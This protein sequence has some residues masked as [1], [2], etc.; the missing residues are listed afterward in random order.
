MAQE[1][2]LRGGTTA[3]HTTFTGAAKEVTVDTTKNILVVHDGATPGGH[4]VAKQSEVDN[5]L[6]LK[7]DALAV[8]NALAL[9]ADTTSVDEALALK[10][11][12]SELATVKFPGQISA[13]A[14]SSAPSGWLKANGA[15][16]SRTAYAALFAEIGVTFGAGD[17]STTFNLPDLRGEFI[18][19]LDDGR[20]I[21]SGRTLGSAQS[22]QNLAH[23]HGVNDPTH[24]HLYGDAA[25]SGN[26]VFTT[27]GG[28]G[29]DVVILETRATAFAATGISIQ[30]SGG[31]EAR[32][33]NVALLY[34]IK[35]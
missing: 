5:S 26:G 21:D 30:D 35:F 4:P 18:R 34:C 20:A 22:S 27:A 13:F 28:T 10:A 6:T 15:A 25:N 14:R 8:T 24:Q 7:A 23:G 3:Q 16:V 33:R 17:G 19:G 32:P 12:A 9:K 1:V 2:R 29:M 31:A 11:D